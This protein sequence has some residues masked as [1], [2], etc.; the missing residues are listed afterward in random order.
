MHT[1]QHISVII[2]VYTTAETLPELYRQLR[3]VLEKHPS[4]NELVFIDDA[5]VDNS[6][7]VLETISRADPRVVLVPLEK[8]VGQ[9]QAIIHGLSRCRGEWAIVMDADLQDSPEVIPLLLSEGLEGYD[10][11]FAARRGMHESPFRMLTSLIFKGFLYMLCGVHPDTGTFVAVNRSMIKRILSMRGP[12]PY[13]PGM[14]HCSGLRISSIP[15]SRSRR[16]AGKTSYSFLGR[17]R[18]A[19]RALSWVT[20]WKVRQSFP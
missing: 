3:Q 18:L 17:V 5:S 20:A 8:N 7:P 13:L 12:Y 6:L 9:H 2:P 15:A 16:K 14:I 1:V 11:V 10:A 19:W 4:D